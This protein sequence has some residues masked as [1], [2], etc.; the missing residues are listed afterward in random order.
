MSEY[1]INLCKM[2]DFIPALNSLDIIAGLTIE[3]IPNIGKIPAYLMDDEM[4]DAIRRQ[5]K[6]HK[7]GR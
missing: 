3:P 6:A 5:V 2:M 1:L 4:V 7:V